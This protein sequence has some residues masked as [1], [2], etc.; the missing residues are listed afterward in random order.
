MTDL[1]ASL[2]GDGSFPDNSNWES[3]AGAVTTRGEAS[4][5]YA[6]AQASPDM[7]A[8]RLKELVRIM[9]DALV[10]EPPF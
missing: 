5:V 2:A 7:T 3:Q 9:Q 10:P 6:Q 4:E 1:L 8:D